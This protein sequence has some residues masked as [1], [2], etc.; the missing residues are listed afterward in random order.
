MKQGNKQGSMD[1]L[2]KGAVLFGLA[3]ATAGVM[4]FADY[5]SNLPS[6]SYPSLCTSPSCQPEVIANERLYGKSEENLPLEEA[7]EYSL[8]EVDMAAHSECKISPSYPASIQQWCNII[9]REAG[10]HGVEPDLIAAM[11]LQESGGQP[12]VMSHSG[13]VGLMQVMPR[14]GI[15][16]EFM[17]INGPCFAN[18]PSIDELLDPEF[19]VQYGTD[20]ISGLISRT[21]S[22]R[23]GLKAYGPMDVGYYYADI[24]LGLMDSYR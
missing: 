5:R 16:A 20:M 10:E 21:G 12:E 24:V 18:R 7:A 14:D 13:A 9:T 11:M 1:G 17:C 23:D 4:W 8:Q 15:A 6:S 19:N 2:T 22:V 3:A